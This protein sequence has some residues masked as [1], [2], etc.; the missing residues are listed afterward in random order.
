MSSGK[1]GCNFWLVCGWFGWFVAGLASLWVHCTKNHIFFFQMFRKDDISK[2]IALEYDLSC[3]I[4]K[5]DISFSQ[6]YDL[7][8]LDGK[9]KMIFL[10][11]IHGNMM[12]SSNVLKRWSFQKNHTG[13]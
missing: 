13:I 3:I 12:F 11:K 6:K 7:I 5:D 8:S 10:K 1:E 9:G 2:I 4:R